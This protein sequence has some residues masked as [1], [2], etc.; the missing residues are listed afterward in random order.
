[1]R[2]F[3][4]GLVVL[5]AVCVL[6]VGDGLLFWLLL[7]PYCFVGLRCGDLFNACLR[8]LVGFVVLVF[9]VV[10]WGVCGLLLVCC[11]LLIVLFI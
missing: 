8:R 2:V 6:I 10:L 9:V 5:V 1:M 3:A 4:V 11:G 7:F